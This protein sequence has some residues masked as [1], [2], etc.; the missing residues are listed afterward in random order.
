MQ[1]RRKFLSSVSEREDM[2]VTLYKQ[3]IACTLSSIVALAELSRIDTGDLL[4]MDEPPS[5]AY[6]SY[7]H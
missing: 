2:A 1:Q 6:I 4:K 7:A 3:L 5:R